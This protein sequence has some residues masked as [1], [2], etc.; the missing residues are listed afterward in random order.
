MRLRFE[1]IPEE[2]QEVNFA[3]HDLGA[4]LLIA[5]ERPAFEFDDLEAEFLLQN[6]PRRACRVD[7]MMRQKITVEFRPF[8]QVALFISVRH[9]GYLF[10]VLHWNFL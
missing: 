5:A 10:V 8:E 7:L 4:D 1:R 3:F 9:E 6:F 2:D